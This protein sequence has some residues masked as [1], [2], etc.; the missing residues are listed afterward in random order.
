MLIDTFRGFGRKKTTSIVNINICGIHI[1]S[2]F[3][4]AAG[5]SNVGFSPFNE[6]MKNKFVI[7]GLIGTVLILI[8]GLTFSFFVIQKIYRVYNPYL[9]YEISGPMTVSEEWT[10]I[11]FTKLL[12]PQRSENEISLDLENTYSPSRNEEGLISSDGSIVSPEIQLVDQ[13]GNIF[14]LN[15]VI[16]LGPQGFS[17][18]MIDPK[19]WQDTLPKDRSYKAIRIRSDKPL[20]VTRIFWR[21]YDPK[22]MK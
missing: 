8:F 9:E 10:E 20:K 7:L 12:S 1:N 17:K 6:Y 22:D 2:T 21:S 5:D 18:G 14:E 13:E 15:K 16:G 4:F 3:Y 11:S 19:T